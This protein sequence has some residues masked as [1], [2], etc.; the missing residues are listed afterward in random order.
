M[1]KSNLFHYSEIVY[2]VYFAGEKKQN[3]LDI[4]KILFLNN[5]FCT[6]AEYKVFLYL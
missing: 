4:S 1:T 6:T 2:Q 5:R 3:F